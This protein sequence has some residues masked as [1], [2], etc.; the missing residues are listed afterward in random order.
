MTQLDWSQVDGRLVYVSVKG[1][2][3]WGVNANGT[4][5]R[6]VNDV[7][8][9]IGG[10]EAKN[11]GCG[12]DGSVWCV[13]KADEIYRFHGLGWERIPGVL[14]YVSVASAN[15]VWSKFIR[16]YLCLG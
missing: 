12:V 2:H 9:H 14:S 6:R 7:W 11:I 8:H 13:S 4:I 3:I 1:E 5:Y 10:C 15:L 16:Q